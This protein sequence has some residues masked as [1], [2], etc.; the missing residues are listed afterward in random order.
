VERFIFEHNLY[1][2]TM[3]EKKVDSFSST[4]GNK[5]SRRQNLEA[6]LHAAT[7][8]DCDI[9]LQ[10]PLK[11]LVRD[12]AKPIWN[13]LTKVEPKVVYPSPHTTATPVAPIARLLHAFFSRLKN[14]QEDESSLRINL[15][16]F[17]LDKVL[18][19]K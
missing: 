15:C 4:P 2:L 1:L 7:I 8:I 19:Y 3:F 9:F 14:E 18:D 11:N 10:D 16:G 13:C 6:N 17:E 5:N 12:L